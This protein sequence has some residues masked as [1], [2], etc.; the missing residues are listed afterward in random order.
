MKPVR[1]HPRMGIGLRAMVAI[2]LVSAAATPWSDGQAGVPTYSIDFHTISNDSSSMQN[3]CFHLY[4]TV[5]QAAPGYSS[6]STY[7]V[8]AGFW[9]AA[10]SIA[11]MDEIFFNGFEGC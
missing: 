6:G 8:I 11:G 2:T 9:P 4:A 7:S 3:S 5:G 1:T 10:V